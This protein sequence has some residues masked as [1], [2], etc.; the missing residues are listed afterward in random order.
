[1]SNPITGPGCYE[2]CQR[3]YNRCKQ[4]PLSTLS[5]KNDT[6]LIRGKFFMVNG[7]NISCACKRCPNGFSK[8][9]HIGDGCIDLVLIHKTSFINNVKLLMTLSSRSKNIVSIISVLVDLIVI[10]IREVRKNTK[11]QKS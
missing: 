1:M 2:N 10:Y 9:C 5:G 8:Y 4:L 6:K 3:C 11:R 7:A